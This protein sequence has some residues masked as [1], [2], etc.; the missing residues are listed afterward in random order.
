MPGT[1]KNLESMAKRY[2]KAWE[3]LYDEHCLKM[4]KEASDE[5]KDQILKTNIA[6][7]KKMIKKNGLEQ[8]MDG[9]KLMEKQNMFFKKY[10]KK[11]KTRRGVR[12]SCIYSKKQGTYIMHSE[13]K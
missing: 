13:S 1:R 4:S 5:Q 9:I 10:N 8:T 2:I 3:L 11:I 12:R 6:N 7:L